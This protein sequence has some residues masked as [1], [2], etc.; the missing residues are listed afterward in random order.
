M[1]EVKK[2]QKD[3]GYP[4]NTQSPFS[5]E[6]DSIKR[7]EKSSEGTDRQTKDNWKNSLDSSV[8]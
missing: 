3:I 2:L 8:L 7:E 6:L 1:M 4:N 5:P